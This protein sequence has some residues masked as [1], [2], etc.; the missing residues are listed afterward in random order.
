MSIDSIDDA[1]SCCKQQVIWARSGARNANPDAEDSDVYE[2]CRAAGI[3]NQIVACP[4]GYDTRV[5]EQG[6][7]LSGGEKQ[8]VALA[9]TIL[10]NTKLILMDEATAALD[11]CTEQHILQS[12]GKFT[13]GCTVVIVANRLST[14]MHAD[15]IMVIHGGRVAE[16]GTHQ[17]LLKMSS[18]YASLW[19]SQSMQPP[20]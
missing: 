13:P 16:S 17:Q 4:D 20:H 14:I 9:Q 12:L 15:K 7:L 5:G 3:H 6:S 2:A 19:F 18:H 1:N 10:K 8:R 11:T